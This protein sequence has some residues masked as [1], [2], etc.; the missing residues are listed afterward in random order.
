MENKHMYDDLPESVERRQ[1]P[2]GGRELEAKLDAARQIDIRQRLLKERRERVNFY[3]D[4]A[5]SVFYSGR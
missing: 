4:L 3:L 5:V 1:P 2:A